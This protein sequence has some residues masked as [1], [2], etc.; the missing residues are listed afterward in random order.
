MNVKVVEFNNGRPFTV[1]IANEKRD[2]VYESY[3][4]EWSKKYQRYLYH[5]SCGGGYKHVITAHDFWASDDANIIVPENSIRRK[6][7]DVIAL[8]EHSWEIDTVWCEQCQDNI[9]KG[10]PCAHI[11]WHD[12]LGW[13]VEVTYCCEEL[14]KDWDADFDVD[15]NKVITGMWSDEHDKCP[16]CGKLPTMVG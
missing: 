12:E 4:F 6:H 1:T 8:L 11:H 10:E 16:F 15:T 5:Y 9:S 2:G 3:N 13:W 14:L 7:Y